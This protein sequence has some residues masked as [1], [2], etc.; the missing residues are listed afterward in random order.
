MSEI[1]DE[2]TRDEEEG[3]GLILR[4]CKDDN[5]NE[6]KELL[7]DKHTSDIA[8][9]LNISDRHDMVKIIA[10]MGEINPDMLPYLE[11]ET[12]DD[13]I[14]LI[15][16]KNS[17]DAIGQ[18]ESDEAIQFVEDLSEENIENILEELELKKKEELQEALNYPEDS[19]GRLVNKQY[20]TTSIDAKVGDIIDMLREDDNL[21][22]DFYTIFVIDKE[23]KPTN[24]VPLSRIMRNKREVKITDLME[25]IIK[26][27]P[28][29][30]DQEDVA[31]SF[32]KYG[33]ISAPVVDDNGFMLGV[34]TV[35]DIADVIREEIEEDIMSLA[36]VGSDSDILS[37]PIK[38]FQNRS[39]W[40]FVNMVTSILAS[41]IISLFEGQIQQIVALAV[42]MPIVASMSGNAGSQTLT[43][44]VRAI[45][46]KELTGSNFL[47]VLRKEF[48]AS[49]MHGLI[50]G[51]VT[52]LAS[53][54]IYHDITLSAVM[55]GSVVITFIL[56]S[57]S[58]SAI[59]LLM[60]KIKFDP[61]VSSSAL[62]YAVTDISSFFIFLG[63]ASIV[64]L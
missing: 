18:L 41:L 21:P 17:A 50:F 11:S 25:D 28:Y 46:T 39:P 3:I 13:I 14:K 54:L 53:Y 51:S 5:L 8:E 30:M 63:I 32:Q 19:A 47:K 31:N 37:G 34:I 22:E 33:L 57:I 58:G 48:V 64:L 42:L 6:L 23:N 49:F 29:D 43:V 56:A 4:A 45:A 38:K 15:G 12:K 40:L 26:V 59:P 62:V 60:H 9:I 61:A 2:I 52:S 10:V 20:I 1:H 36:G 16:A 35:D 27:I 44:I 7:K 55:L 24:F